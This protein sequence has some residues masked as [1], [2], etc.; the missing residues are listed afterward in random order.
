MGYDRGP[1]VNYNQSHLQLQ[2]KEALMN[3]KTFIIA[4]LIAWIATVLN[5]QQVLA[6]E[7][8]TVGDYTVE[9]GW[10]NE[11]VV[12]GQ[13]NAIVVNVSTTGDEQP[14]EDVSGLTVMISYGGQNKDLALQPL[15]EDSPGQFAAPILPTIAGQYTI[16][17]G[18]VLGE[19]VVDVEVEPE[20]VQ[21]ASTLQFPSLQPAPQSSGNEMGDWLT[22]LAVLLGLIGIGLGVTAL[23]RTR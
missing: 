12:A 10:L 13:Q 3:K 5:F 22:W 11:P 8:I 20:E 2:S 9:I 19:T 23:R 21:S 15:G 4:C 1:E 18:G 7:S 16:Q 6:H 17:L 14:V